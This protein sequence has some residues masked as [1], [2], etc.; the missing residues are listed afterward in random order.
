MKK[1]S[2]RPVSTARPEELRKSPPEENSL[3]SSPSSDKTAAPLVDS[4]GLKPE[5]YQVL[6]E[7]PPEQYE[8]L[9]ADIAERGV[10]VPVIVDEFGNFID[11]H[12]RARACRELGINDY[13]VEV[14]SGLTEAEK[15]VLAHKLNVL[16]RHLTREQVR[17]SAINY[18]TPRSGPTAASAVNWAS[19]HKTVG[20]VRAA[21]GSTGEIPQLEKTVGDD[22][23]ARPA[24]HGRKRRP[25]LDETWDDDGDEDDDQPRQPGRGRRVDAWDDPTRQA[26]FAHAIDLMKLEVDPHSEQVAKL[27]QPDLVIKN[28]PA[29]VGTHREWYLF[30]LFLVREWNWWPEAAAAASLKVAHACLNSS[31]GSLVRKRRPSSPSHSSGSVND[32]YSTCEQRQIACGD[33][34]RDRGDLQRAWPHA[35]AS[36][37]TTETQTRCGDRTMTVKITRCPP[38]R[39]YGCDDLHRWASRRIAGRSGVPLSKAERKLGKRETFD[40]CMDAATDRWVE[41][42]ERRQRNNKTSDDVFVQR[43]RDGLDRLTARGRRRT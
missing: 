25:A 41:Q 43:P 6:P 3:A 31:V 36:T 38:G 21:L 14:R 30:I 7:L 34:Q 32:A 28:T 42:A 11:G 35:A 24:G 19:I 15:R 18:G 27:L 2:G 23:K 26:K 40:E 22:G 37:Y 10:M 39:A 8:A 9:K 13:P 16:R 17:R 4:A 1:R 33:Q 20:S 5:K 12:N 29:R